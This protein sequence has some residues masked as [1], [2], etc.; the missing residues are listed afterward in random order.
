LTGE[1]IDL[2][3][4]EQVQDIDQF[5]LRY[6][7]LQDTMGSRLFTS[8]LNY[9][10]EPV[11]NRAMLDVLH[12]L[13]KLGLIESTEMWQKVRIVRNRFAHDYAN[14]PEKN[15]A[16]LNMAFASTLDLYNMLNAIRTWFRNA[17]PTLEL[18]KE[19]PKMPADA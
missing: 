6:T 16:Q 8:I 13:E 9:L 12:R 4:D 1:S 10:Y 19:L 2:L 18:G 11:D 17:Y 15:A 14:D 3:T 5:I 7:K